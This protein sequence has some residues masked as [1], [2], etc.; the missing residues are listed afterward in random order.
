MDCQGEK[1][2]KKKEKCHNLMVPE[3]RRFVNT[4]DFLV[5]RSFHLIPGT[6]AKR[7]LITCLS[8]FL[9]RMRVMMYLSLRY[10]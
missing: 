7:H 9:D 2:Y 4:I 3:V 10:L 8:G 6:V 5:H 1:E